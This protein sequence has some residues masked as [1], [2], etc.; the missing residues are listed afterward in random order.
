[1]VHPNWDYDNPPYCDVFWGS[2]GCSLPPGHDEPCVCIT[3]IYDEDDNIVE[4]YREGNCAPP[5]FGPD[6][7]F[8]TNHDTPIPEQ[9]LAARHLKR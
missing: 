9:T 5:Y 6:T 8:M 3:N 4:T 7:E 2:H 1:M